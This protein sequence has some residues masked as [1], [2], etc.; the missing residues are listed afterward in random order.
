MPPS[1]IP[2]RRLDLIERELSK[3]LFEYPGESALDR[4][5]FVR[6]LVRV[7]KNQMEVDDDADIPVLDIELHGR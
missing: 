1:Q 4:L 5:E 7:M 6:A 3:A 2:I